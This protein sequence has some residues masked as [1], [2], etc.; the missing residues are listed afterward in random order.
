MKGFNIHGTVVNTADLNI[1]SQ[2]M[3]QSEEFPCHKVLDP[4]TLHLFHI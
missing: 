3:F 4:S 1:T 2:T